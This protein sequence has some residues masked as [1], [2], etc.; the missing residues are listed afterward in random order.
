MQDV[1]QQGVPKD[2]PDEGSQGKDR[3][4]RRRYSLK[5]WNRKWDRLGRGP[6]SEYITS[7]SRNIREALKWA[8][9]VR[10]LR[11]E[12]GHGIF[13]IC[14]TEGE[15]TLVLSWDTPAADETK[16]R[17]SRQ[18]SGRPGPRRRHPVCLR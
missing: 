17:F 18:S 6:I 1:Q 3:L 5:P 11:I 9:S 14:C 13:E 4:R 12:N 16:G 7:D 2:E 8:S 10:A 15:A